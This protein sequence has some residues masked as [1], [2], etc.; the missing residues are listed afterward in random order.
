MPL[1][2]TVNS[3]N[4]TYM[5][6]FVFVFNSVGI[7]LLHP[8]QIISVELGVFCITDNTHWV[9][10]LLIIKCTVSSSGFKQEF[11]FCSPFNPNDHTHSHARPRTYT[12]AHKQVCSHLSVTRSALSRAL[13]SFD[14][15]SVN[16]AGA[17]QMSAI[18]KCTQSLREI[19]MLFCCVFVFVCASVCVCVGSYSMYEFT[20]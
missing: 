16:T 13:L 11:T 14:M 10:I 8:L 2:Y 15:F 5:L 18:E 9:V 20:D 6:S 7:I 3:T 12:D 17:L 4:E 19:M 1:S